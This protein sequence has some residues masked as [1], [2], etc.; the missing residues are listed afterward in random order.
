MREFSRFRYGKENTDV[1]AAWE[2]LRTTLY[3]HNAGRTIVTTFPSLECEY[4]HYP[5]SALARTWRLLLQRLARIVQPRPTGT[6]SSTSRVKPS[7]ITPGSCTPGRRPRPGQKRRRF[8]AQASAEFVQLLR[9]LDELLATSDEFLLGRW[10]EDSAPGA[11]PPRRRPRLEWN[12][13][14]ILTLWGGEPHSGITPGR[15]GPAS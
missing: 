2:T 14:R 7:P 9:D 15:N 5:H 3:I 12:A 4:T 11:I 13:R 6:I 10:L 8:L 1:Q